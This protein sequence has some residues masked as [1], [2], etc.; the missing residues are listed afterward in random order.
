MSGED[1]IKPAAIA[2]EAELEDR[3]L[4]VLT[5]RLR[6]YSQSQ[7]GKVLGVDQ[8]TVSRDL[9][10]IEAHRKTLFGQ[11][12][13]IDIEHEIGEAYD[14]YCD[15]EWKALRAASKGD[16][17]AQNAYLRT[18]ILARGQRMA[19][20]QDLGMIDR[21]LGTMGLTFRADAVR[22]ALREE[23]LL[24]SDRNPATSD[25]DDDEVERWLRQA[26]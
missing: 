8:S 6:K 13:K 20:L 16:A 24:V 12:A 22:L 21:Q 10:W 26:V 18:A 17:K 1:G 11:P 2:T 5:L 23:G 15:V 14:F 4:Q 9:A 7:I 19:L 25:E 3:R